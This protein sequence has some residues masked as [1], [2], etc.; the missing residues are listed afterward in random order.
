MIGPLAD[1]PGAMNR[2]AALEAREEK[3]R[4]RDVDGKQFALFGAMH[5]DTRR[6]TG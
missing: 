6:R 1:W 4:S 3:V 2:G 5:T